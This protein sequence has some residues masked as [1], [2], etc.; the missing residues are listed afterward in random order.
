MTGATIS[1]VIVTNFAERPCHERF[2]RVSYVLIA[3]LVRRGRRAG[4][5]SLEVALF[6]SCWRSEIVKGIGHAGECLYESWGVFL[7]AF[8]SNFRIRFLISEK[9]P[10]TSKPACA[11]SPSKDGLPC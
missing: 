4:A 6:T 7:R 10:P 1:M 3:P 8:F 11:K 5:P 9:P 2:L